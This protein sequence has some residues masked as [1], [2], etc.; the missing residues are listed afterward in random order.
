MRP[1]MI[2]YEDMSMRLFY[3]CREEA[4][5]RREERYARRGTGDIQRGGEKAAGERR[6]KR[7]RYRQ[8]EMRDMR[9]SREARVCGREAER[10]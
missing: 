7:W 6:E 9:E 4:R 3:I 10:D 5:A 2:V 8:R 1:E